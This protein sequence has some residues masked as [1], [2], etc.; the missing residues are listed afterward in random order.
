VRYSTDMVR[1]DSEHTQLIPVR[2]ASPLTDGAT[3]ALPPLRLPD[4]TLTHGVPFTRARSQTITN[5][6]SVV[7]EEEERDTLPPTGSWAHVDL[8]DADED[9]VT[10]RPPPPGTLPPTGFGTQPPPGTLPPVAFGSAEGGRAPNPFVDGVTAHL[11]PSVPLAP[12]LPFFAA[13]ESSPRPAASARSLADLRAELER[14]GPVSV[15]RASFETIPPPSAPLTPM[16]TETLAVPQGFSF[17][18]GTMPP[19]AP[20]HATGFTPSPMPAAPALLARAPRANAPTVEPELR[21][22]GFTLEEFSALRAALASDPSKRK[23][24]L[25]ARGLGEVRFRVCERRW[26]A[27]FRA[28]EVAPGALLEGV[29]AAR[30]AAATVAPATITPARIEASPARPADG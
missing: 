23:A 26:A 28:M 24:L 8:E 20:T 29:R 27:H 6:A 25:R 9:V 22:E 16:P 14:P 10:V 11:S 15:A 21:I 7:L 5:E 2:D 3:E 30:R 17:D 18:P 19:P 4:A 1:R 13:P 12:A